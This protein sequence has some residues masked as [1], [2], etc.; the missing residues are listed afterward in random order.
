MFFS[1]DRDVKEL[2]EKKKNP[3]EENFSG[4]VKDIETKLKEGSKPEKKPKDLLRAIGTIIQSAK[5]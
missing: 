2:Q 4:R 1:Q 5:A 3:M